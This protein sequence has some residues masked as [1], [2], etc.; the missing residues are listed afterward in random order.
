[1]LRG[2]SRFGLLT[3]YCLLRRDLR[4]GIAPTTLA[5]GANCRNAEPVA[6]TGSETLDGRAG[7]CRNA[8]MLP[9][10]RGRWIA[11]LFDDVTLC[12]WQSVPGQIN[13]TIMIT[14][15]GAQRRRQSRR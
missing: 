1:M 14:G 8:G 12:F 13:F 10:C 11:A 3:A 6:R 2:G 9:T 4:G 15:S 7:F 5:G